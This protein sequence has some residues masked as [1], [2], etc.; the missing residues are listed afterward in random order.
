MVH[1]FNGSLVPSADIRI[2]TNE[3]MTSELMNL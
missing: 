3:L 1:L 2:A